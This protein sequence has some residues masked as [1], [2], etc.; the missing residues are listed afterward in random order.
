VAPTIVFGFYGAWLIYRR[1]DRDF[2]WFV[3][4]ALVT[5]LGVVSCW[6]A[7]YGGMCFGPR[8]MVPVLPLASLGMVEVVDR[9]RWK[10]P[11]RLAIAWGA[12]VQLLGVSLVHE[13]DAYLWLAPDGSNESLA[14]FSPAHST[15]VLMPRDVLLAPSHVR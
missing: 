7:W 3:A 6:W 4:A 15:S 10:W 12:Y 8:L 9:A 14:W 13:Y 1:G 5:L 2:P 11:L